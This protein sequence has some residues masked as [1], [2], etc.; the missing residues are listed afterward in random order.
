[1]KQHTSNLSVTGLILG[2]MSV[3][4]V[5]GGYTA[6]LGIVFGLFGILF[7]ARGRRVQQTGLAKHAMRISVFGFILCLLI[8][9]LLIALYLYSGLQTEFD[10]DLHS[11]YDKVRE[12]FVR[13]RA[14]I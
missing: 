8:S 14:H 7:S 3:I 4:T 13:I 2:I 10:F 1:M 12:I 6:L 11:L 5:F 9:G